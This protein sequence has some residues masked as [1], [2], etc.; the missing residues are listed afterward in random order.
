MRNCKTWRFLSCYLASSE[1]R[2]GTNSW[3]LFTFFLCCSSSRI[4][5]TLCHDTAP[6]SGA[7][8]LLS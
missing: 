2:T 8:S 3:A 4:R 5:V 7:A 6:P 1:N